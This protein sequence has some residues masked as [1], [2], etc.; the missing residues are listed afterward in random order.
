MVVGS[1]KK[2]DELVEKKRP[3][4]VTDNPF[5]TPAASPGP[6][7]LEDFYHVFAPP[8]PND[9]NGAGQVHY[10]DRMN[11]L[12]NGQEVVVS[13][14]GMSQYGLQGSGASACGLAAMNCV[15]L[16]LR[17]ARQ[18]M[19]GEDLIMRAMTQ[20]TTLVRFSFFFFRSLISS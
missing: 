20:Q 15:R 8:R 13:F 5:V 10:D 2:R 7:R 6:D 16:L 18:G 14:P 4:I 17:M 11:D 19:S 3:D 9:A 12:M 1:A